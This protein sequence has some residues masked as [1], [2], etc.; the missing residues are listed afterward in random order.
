MKTLLTLFL[1]IPSFSWANIKLVCQG[2]SMV[3]VL[4]LNTGD[5]FSSAKYYEKPTVT[6]DEGKRM[7]QVD[8]VSDGIVGY[9]FQ[10]WRDTEDGFYGYSLDWGGRTTGYIH[11][12]RFSGDMIRMTYLPN[13]QEK[14]GLLEYYYNCKKASKKF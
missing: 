6:I 2:H 14:E 7:I 11:I 1:L 10:S 8:G 12:D 5:Q 4:Y 13:E 9:R 3:Q